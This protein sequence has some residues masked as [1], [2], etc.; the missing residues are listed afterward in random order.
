[1]A[2]GGIFP[3]FSSSPASVVCTL[4]LYLARSLSASFMQPLRSFMT[5]SLAVVAS[6]SASVTSSGLTEMR[7][8]Q[9]VLAFTH[10]TLSL[11]ITWIQPSELFLRAKLISSFHVCNLYLTRV[12]LYGRL[13]NFTFPFLTFGTVDFVAFHPFVSE[14]HLVAAA[15]R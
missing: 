4:V 14:G 15:V 1:M 6:V 10:T 8:Q 13:A 11:D 9:D 12:N 3:N 5:S 2:H 7:E